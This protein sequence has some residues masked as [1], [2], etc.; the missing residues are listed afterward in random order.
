[1]PRTSVSI[2]AGLTS[3]N[4]VIRVVGLSVTEIRGRLGL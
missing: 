3:R 2:A 4:K 1:V